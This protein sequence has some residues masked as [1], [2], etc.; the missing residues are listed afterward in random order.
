MKA[1]I[2]LQ[3][4]TQSLS[5][6]LTLVSQRLPFI[7]HFAPL[8]SSPASLRIATPLL[9]TFAGTHTLTGQTTQILAV[10]G[11]ENPLNLE[12]GQEFT[13]QFDSARY[14]ASSSEVTGLPPG[15]TYTFGYE[16][17]FNGQ[18][19]RLTR[20]GTID[21]SITA[22]GI[23]Q[24][25]IVGYRFSGLRGNQTPPYTLTINVT[26][27]FV[28][29]PTTA[30]LFEEWRDQNWI[31]LETTDDAISGPNADPDGDD[32]PNLLEFT[33]DLD[34]NEALRFEQTAGHFF[35]T[36][37]EDDTKLIWEIPYTGTGNLTIEETTDPSNE[38]SWTSVAE[39]NIELT[40]NFLRME[41]PF[42]D[43]PKKYF[44]LRATF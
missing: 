14:S 19:F 6:T 18:V 39:A 30:E 22:P 11:S 37:P 33:L 25:T 1:S 16:T 29:P 8:I 17:E 27:P 32:I 35:G 41:S 13:W 23:Y 24:V 31:G 12:V 3:K 2:I 5:T 9:T 15:A 4:T 38:E 40:P 20:G 10:E 34:P 36:F 43:G 44:R 7:Q 26:E 21:G 42:S 28:E